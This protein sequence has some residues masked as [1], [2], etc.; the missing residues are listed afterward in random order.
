MSQKRAERREREKAEGRRA[1]QA[2]GQAATFYPRPHPT[3][4]FTYNLQ[5]IA[6][7]PT[8]RRPS[9]ARTHQGKH[10]QGS[11]FFSLPFL[12]ARWT[13]IPSF[14]PSDSLSVLVDITRQLEKCIC[15]HA[16]VG[17]TCV[18]YIPAL[19]EGFLTA[20]H[21]SCMLWL[22]AFGRPG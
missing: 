16:D 15:L 17:H 20:S 3:P 9:L 10:H 7:F 2:Q 4:H 21:E 8:R 22:V 12:F 19:M 6:L 1:E 18:L 14:R 11:L 5:S 13:L